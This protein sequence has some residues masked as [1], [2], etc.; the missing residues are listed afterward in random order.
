MADATEAGAQLP[1]RRPGRALRAAIYARV[2]TLHHGQDVG[3]QVDEL[4]EVCAQRG[5]VI[6]GEFI[7]DGVSGAKTS[8]PALDRMLADA[9]RGR[10][11][12]LLVWKLDRLARSLTHL[13][14]VCEALNAAGVGFI[15]VHDP[16]VDTST[17]AGR[18]LLQIC[19]AFSELERSILRERV[20]AG[21]RRAQAM[22]KRCGRPR[23]EL[24][25]RPALALLH[26]GRGLKEVA[27]IL[28]I[29]RATLR[30]RLEEAGAWP[31]RA[32]AS[33]PP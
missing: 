29:A 18:L 13:L 9:Q 14:T 10:F 8:R 30:R 4:R 3:L 21:V 32:D 24:D 26:Q 23:V 6:V 20:I 12:L 2:S 31:P 25:L 22:G 17:P 1:A 28:E 15:S 7:D 16:G 27:R 19:G 11:D 33:A 5:Y